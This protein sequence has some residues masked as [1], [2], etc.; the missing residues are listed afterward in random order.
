MYSADTF[1]S[2]LVEAAL[3]FGRSVTVLFGLGREAEAVYLR[4]RRGGGRV[5]L[6]VAPSAPA[7]EI[8][9]SGTEVIVSVTTSSLRSVRAW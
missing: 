4:L 6:W 5:I 3:R 9:P 2:W 8:R 1:I 7:A